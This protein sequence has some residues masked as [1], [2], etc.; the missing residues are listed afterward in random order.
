MSEFADI[1]YTA[2]IAKCR[3]TYEHI[4]D[5]ADDVPIRT[6]VDYWREAPFSK[7]YHPDHLLFGNE[8]NKVTATSSQLS[9]EAHKR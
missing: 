2:A 4:S 7:P 6:K 8:P 3:G 5:I 1:R 9:Q